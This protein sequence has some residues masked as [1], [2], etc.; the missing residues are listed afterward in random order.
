MK[1]FILGAICLLAGCTGADYGAR[2]TAGD[3]ALG[4]VPQSWQTAQA[5][6]SEV[7]V[8]W[9]ETFGDSLL[10][11]LVEDALAHNRNLQAA[12]ANVDR[13]WALARQAGAAV[14]PALGLAAGTGRG[15]LMEGGTASSG[16]SLGLQASWELDLWGRIGAGRGAAVSSA[17]AAAADYLFA[18]YS[19]AA[20]VARAYFVAIEAGL[21]QKTALKVTEAL[22]ETL[23]IVELRFQ[24]GLASA[25]DLALVRGD[26]A[27]AREA[28][29]ATAGGQ[30]DALRAL[31]LLLGRYPAAELELRADLPQAPAQPPV[32]VPSS[33]L[34]RRPDLV[35]AE[36]RIAATVAGVDQAKAARLPS[37]SLTAEAGGSS[38][39]LSGLLDPVNVAWQAAASLLVP[40]VDGGARKAQIQVAGA[41]STAAV[42]AYAQAALV[43]FGEVERALDQGH[44]LTQRMKNLDE[45]RDEAKEA[46]RL[47]KLRY[48]EGETDL[49]DVLTIQQRFDGRESAVFSLQRN[50]LEQHLDLHLALGGHW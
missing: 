30:R 6:M 32:G 5:E 13:A 10:S 14:T 9:I 46:L 37:L 11:K 33:L 4:E 42:A 27:S 21:Q 36:R 38:G 23:R 22:E 34:E 12:A 47:T 24:E 20:A 29:E 43:A 8:G 31:E 35:A 1:K 3:N 18:Q 49:L 48:D 41:E 16:Q 17:Q 39:G 28:L 2:Q 15:G 7:E 26:L 40:I 25:Q 50:L 44:V 45:A 19:L